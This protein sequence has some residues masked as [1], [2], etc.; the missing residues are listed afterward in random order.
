MG[1][2]TAVAIALLVNICVPVLG[3]TGDQVPPAYPIVSVHVP[4][5]NKSLPLRFMNSFSLWF[6]A[7]AFGA[8][9]RASVAADLFAKDD[10]L[11]R[12]TR[13]IGTS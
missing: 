10:L 6:C 7:A 1:A 13:I 11:H 3:I 2:D 9:D 8:I 12:V 4:E 5:R